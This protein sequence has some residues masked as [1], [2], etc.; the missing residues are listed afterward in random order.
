MVKAAPAATT[1]A[2]F[3]RNGRAIGFRSQH[4]HHGGDTVEHGGGEKREPSSAEDVPL[5]AFSV[6]DLKGGQVQRQRRLLGRDKGRQ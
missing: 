3:P 6:R 4:H 5:E 1:A 2:V